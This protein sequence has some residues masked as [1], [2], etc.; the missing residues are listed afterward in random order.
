MIEPT[1]ND[2]FVQEE[3]EGTTPDGL[4]VW[5]LGCNGFVLRTPTT[6]IYIDPYF[7][8]GDHRPYAVRML[9]V[10]MD[11]E[12]ATLCDAVL[13]THEHVDHMHPTSHGPLLED[14]DANVFAPETCFRDPDYDGDVSVP[15]ERQIAVAPGKVI[16]VGD[17][18]IHVRGAYDP[19]AAEPVSYVVESEWGTFF[20]PGDSKPM[21]EFEEIGTSFDVEVGALA[22]GSVGKF[23][24]PE[25]GETRRTKWYMNGDE[26]IESCNALRLDRLLPTHHDMWKGFRASPSGL[27]DNA[28]SS[29]YPR[30]ISVVEV[31]D[32][33]EVGKPG[34][35]PP[36]YTR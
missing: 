1:W 3:L 19:D 33:I 6:T 17:L 11:P 31:G 7:G 35:I 14:T 9:P 12:N 15:D 4:S 5:Y 30:T 28:S 24:E 32:R 23:V 34:V 25:S 13:I 16:E 27:H 18:T 8:T 36:S 21:P 20:H 10:P 22:F 26:V 29:T 2:W